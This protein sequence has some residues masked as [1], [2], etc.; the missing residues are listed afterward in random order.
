ME[1]L[2]ELPFSKKFD[3][4]LRISASDTFS[5]LDTRLT[6]TSRASKSNDR[7]S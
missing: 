1:A 5:Q 7:T 4:L 2:P 3:G 6:L